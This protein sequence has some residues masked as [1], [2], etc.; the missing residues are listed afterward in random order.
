MCTAVSQVKVTLK[1]QQ[2]TM[3]NFNDERTICT[4]LAEMCYWCTTTDDVHLTK[5]TQTLI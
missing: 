3:A 1:L 5:H 2:P 4:P